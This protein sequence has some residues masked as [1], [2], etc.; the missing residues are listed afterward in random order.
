[1]DNLALRTG[2]V[3]AIGRAI[4]A[5]PLPLLYVV[6]F[7]DDDAEKMRLLASAG[8]PGGRRRGL[9][10]CND[11][12]ILARAAAKGGGVCEWDARAAGC[13]VGRLV[14]RRAV[15]LVMIADEVLGGWGSRRGGKSSL[16][17]TCDVTSETKKLS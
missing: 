17:P 6:D 14:A 15:A 4:K 1:M 16:Q 10:Q 8:A 9:D 2:D 11:A 5:W 12:R 7:D 13:G 3:I